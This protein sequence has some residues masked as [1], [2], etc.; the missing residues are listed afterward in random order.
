MKINKFSYISLI[1][2]YFIIKLKKCVISKKMYLMVQDII[3][4]NFHDYDNCNYNLHNKT[5]KVVLS[6]ELQ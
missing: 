5:E 2:K 1:I 6:F 3:H 4:H